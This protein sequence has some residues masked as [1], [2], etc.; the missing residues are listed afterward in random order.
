MVRV[1]SPIQEHYFWSNMIFIAP[2][3]LN[4]RC[5]SDPYVYLYMTLDSIIS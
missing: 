2:Y 4:F 5:R 1:E 3:I